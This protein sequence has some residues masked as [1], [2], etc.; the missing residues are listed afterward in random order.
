M[1]TTVSV[2]R[3][4]STANEWIL[5]ISEKAKRGRAFSLGVITPS[6]PK[7]SI[8]ATTASSSSTDS[9]S[10]FP[11]L[12]HSKDIRI[13]HLDP[14]LGP[15]D[16]LVGHYE[17]C[18]LES[19][20][21]YEALSYTWDPPFKGQI[22]PDDFV[23]ISGLLFR[24]NGN[25][26]QALRRLRHTDQD[27]A[28]WIDAICINQHSVP[29]R[30]SQVAMM[31]DIYRS[32]A[33][34]ILWLGED[35]AIRDGQYVFHMATGLGRPSSLKGKGKKRDSPLGN[36]MPEVEDGGISLEELS[37][38]FLGRKVFQRRWIIQEL[39]NAG[40]LE[41][42]CGSYLMPWFPFFKSLQAL[43]HHR[44]LYES[45]NWQF[46]DR[47][48]M[49]EDVRQAG[50]LSRNHTAVDMLCAVGNLGC[51]DPRDRLFALASLWSEGFIM[52]DYAL[53][54]EEVYYNFAMATVAASVKAHRLEARSVLHANQLLLVAAY[55]AGDR[56]RMGMYS[57]PSWAPHWHFTTPPKFSLSAG[58]SLVQPLHVTRNRILRA[59]VP[60]FGTIDA[61]LE[62]NCLRLLSHS[63]ARHANLNESITYREHFERYCPALRN[64]DLLCGPVLEHHSLDTRLA[65][66]LRGNVQ[67]H[68]MRV[69]MVGLFPMDLFGESL[70]DHS[71]SMEMEFL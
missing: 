19:R 44:P 9:A 23:E 27:R 52:I 39:C 48:T 22:L 71:M 15:D 2:Q 64:G 49:L 25:L 56:R 35:S 69:R 13:L 61:L 66:V 12:Q 28:L 32:S 29:E 67:E 20:P 57:L 42:L 21:V 47:L 70:R 11:P 4:H 60:I 16:P 30:G 17:L 45:Q 62:G 3:R 37:Q 58:D 24:V 8:A 33:R 7:N 18:A 1:A 6:S 10:P 50:G 46:S 43:L 59:N 63:G 51:R 40:N 5:K 54:A 41:V 68:V 55:Q 31:A 38:T 65:I 14:S 26:G 53:A 36:L 34:T